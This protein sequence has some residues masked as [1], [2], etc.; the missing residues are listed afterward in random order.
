MLLNEDLDLF[1]RYA[2]MFALRNRGSPEAVDAIVAT[3]A[4]RSALLRHE[5]RCFSFASWPVPWFS[6]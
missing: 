1:D 3:L 5:V 4:A 2:A 6:E